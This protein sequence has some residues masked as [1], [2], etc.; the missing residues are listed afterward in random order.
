MEHLNV[1]VA[2]D[3]ILVEV[4]V[5]VNTA[6]ALAVVDNVAVVVDAVTVVVEFLIIL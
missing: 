3:H 1:G 6:T 5:N 4:V 2:V